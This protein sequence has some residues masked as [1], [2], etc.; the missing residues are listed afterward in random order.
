M[1][2]SN[3]TAAAIAPT[4][5]PASFIDRLTDFACGAK[6]SDIDPQSLQHLK[7]I[8]ADTLAAFAAGN[9]EPEM[10]A[11][12]AKQKPL[13]SS[14]HASVVGTDCTLNPIDAA[15]LNASAGCW[16]ELDEG[17][18]TSNGHP[19][20]QVIPTALAVAQELGK[21]G[22]EFLLA[23]AIGY[24]ICARIGSA[25]D[26]RMC[27]HPHGT[28]GVIG[29]AVAAARLQ[30]VSRSEMRELINLAGSS[31]IAG[32]RQS[33]KDGAT[34]RNW[35]AS[36]SAIMGQMSVR[37][38]QSGFT[39][40]H[41]GITPTC[42]EV[43][44]DNFKPEVAV[45]DLGKKWILG[46]GYI[47]LYGCGR[48]I[49][50][51][52]DAVRGA[53]APLGDTSNWPTADEIASIDIRGYKFLA[54]LNRRDIR[55]AFATR[56]STPF[57]VASVIVN[58]GWGLECFDDAAAADKT[59]DAL[60]QKVEL[61]EV[62]EYSD[63]FPIKQICDL[64]ITLKNGTKFVGRTDVIRGEPANPADASD[65]RDK[66]MDMAVRAW[67]ADKLDAL[68]DAAMNVDKLGNMRDLPT[69]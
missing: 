5:A 40:P 24:E 1:T 38:V 47:K 10:K 14:G 61:S 57:A 23:C 48:P 13:V 33:M 35:Y 46:D 25:C 12:L 4:S 53:L 66:F 3:S 20:I 62:P 9:Q 22:E 16:L 43:L 55:N 52:I 59:I 45:Q 42:D 50:S 28:Y 31:P 7:V 30:G 11:L 8:V 37:L 34:L 32:N 44:F 15:A 17:N 69:R 64:T 18:L 29:G 2:F 63:Q 68:F 54:F 51:A 26:M 36:H 21:S 41:D 65:Y 58:R 19:G 60:V 27:I 39:G 49:H 56:F 67:P 6:L